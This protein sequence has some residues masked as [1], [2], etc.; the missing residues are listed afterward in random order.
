MTPTLEQ[1]TE[2]LMRY[3]QQQCTGTPECP[4]PHQAL[5]VL[6]EHTQGEEVERQRRLVR[7][8][9]RTLYLVLQAAGTVRVQ[10]WAVRNYD[11]TGA[12]IVKFR[13]P[14]S[15]ADYYMAGLMPR[16]EG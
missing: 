11:A 8:L 3:T 10:D 14:E 2:E 1:A 6:L 7:D 5:V 12:A 13:S 9:T 4:V 16:R 15:E